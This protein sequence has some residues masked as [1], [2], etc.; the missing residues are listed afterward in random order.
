MQAKPC[1]T[2]SIDPHHGEILM[3]LWVRSMTVVNS[4]FGDH[5]V[6]LFVRKTAS[7]SN[8]RRSQKLIRHLPPMN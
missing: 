6:P 4:G 8:F 7:D 2:P 5:G 1:N 3:K